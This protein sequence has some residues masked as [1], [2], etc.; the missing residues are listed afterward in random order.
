MHILANDTNCRM[1]TRM[2]QIRN[3]TNK[4]SK[5]IKKRLE[6]NQRRTKSLVTL[7]RKKVR[8]MIRKMIMKKMKRKM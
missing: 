8:K 1:I 3:L 7:T 4:N 5:S 2:S 6:S